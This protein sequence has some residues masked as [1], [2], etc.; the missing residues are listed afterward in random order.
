[1]KP[2]LQMTQWS[3]GTVNVWP[4]NKR[5]SDWQ[6]RLCRWTTV[7]NV[8]QD[9]AVLPLS[10]NTNMNYST[11]SSLF[12]RKVIYLSKKT[13][14]F[15]LHP[16][17][18]KYSLFCPVLDTSA[19]VSMLLSLLNILFLCVVN[20]EKAKLFTHVLFLSPVGVSSW[21]VRVEVI[22]FRPQP[23]DFLLFVKLLGF[24]ICISLWATLHNV[25]IVTEDELNLIRGT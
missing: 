5:D 20:N 11:S 18:L 3:Q 22:G 10:V 17:L 24:F 14:F 7:S 2:P 1:M 16:F 19:F 21:T 9:R 12:P 4:F 6:K 8:Q 25:C 23:S 13:A 15:K